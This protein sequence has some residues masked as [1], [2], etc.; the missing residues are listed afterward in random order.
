[1]CVCRNWNKFF[2]HTIT[3]KVMIRP[4]I[5]HWTYKTVR[6]RKKEAEVSIFMCKWLW[7]GVKWWYYHWKCNF[8]TRW[9]REEKRWCEKWLLL[10]WID[11]I[12]L[13]FRRLFV[14]VPY[15]CCTFA[16]I[17][18]FNKTIFFSIVLSSFSLVKIN[19]FCPEY[20]YHV[21]RKTGT[22]FWRPEMTWQVDFCLVWW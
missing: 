4:F 22:L 7:Q 3:R 2:L 16:P 18:E 17:S 5:E 14:T 9:N 11:F 15:N 1:M 19:Y 12:L 8:S 20:Q 6:E 21:G 10:G 13:F